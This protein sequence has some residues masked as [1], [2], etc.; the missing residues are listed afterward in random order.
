ML[1]IVLAVSLSALIAGSALA[2]SGASTRGK[3]DKEASKYLEA[4]S[5]ANDSKDWANVILNADKALAVEK[6]GSAVQYVAHQLRAV[7]HLQKDPKNACKIILPDLQFVTAADQIVLKDKPDADK[8]KSAAQFLS[9]QGKCM[10]EQNVGDK[11]IASYTAAIELDPQDS[12]YYQGRCFVY[13][14]SEQHEKAIADCEKASMLNQTDVQS[15]KVIGS[16]YHKMGKKKEALEA[17]E[18]VLEVA[19]NDE[20]AKKNVEGLKKEVAKG[21]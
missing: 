3:G 6:T 10:N 17:W 16:A 11:G 14:Q 9:L 4:G 15:L 8:A 7:G 1:R 5:K 19:P 18:S 12:T 2:A 20:M 13:Y 21:Q